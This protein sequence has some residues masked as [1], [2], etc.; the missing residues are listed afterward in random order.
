MEWVKVSCTAR[1]MV[2]RNILRW[3]L[4]SRKTEMVVATH[5]HSHMFNYWAH[6]YTHVPEIYLLFFLFFIIHPLALCPP[7]HLHMCAIL[8]EIFRGE[9]LV[10]EKAEEKAAMMRTRV[11]AAAKSN[12]PSVLEASILS[13]SHRV[14]V[15]EMYIL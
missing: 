10:R 2:K 14:Y 3:K 4:L 5:W 7:Y 6:T 9:I 11:A 12:S 1:K 13:L 15:C 8:H